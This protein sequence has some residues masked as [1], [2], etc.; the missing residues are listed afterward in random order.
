ME[1]IILKSL[2]T[3]PNTV[4]FYSIY[5]TIMLTFNSSFTCYLKVI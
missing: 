5:L 3:V 1:K 2:L 4:E